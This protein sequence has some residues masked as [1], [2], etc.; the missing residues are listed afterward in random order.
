MNYETLTILSYI[1]AALSVVLLAVGVVL[2]FKL[3]IK[4]VIGDLTGA[5]QRKAIES[6]KAGN[7]TS[8]DSIPSSNNAAKTPKTSAKTSAPKIEKSGNTA[9]EI[10]AEAEKRK[11]S[12]VANE[13]DGVTEVLGVNA[14]D[15]DDVDSVTTVLTSEIEE[16]DDE[17]VTSVLGVQAVDEDDDEGVTSVLGVQRIDDNEGFEDGITFVHGKTL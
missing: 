12:L 8:A 16:E 13:N 1:A 2:F 17:G 10:S 11:V 6:I 9:N 5:N 7:K 14:I 4:N 3:K 15:D